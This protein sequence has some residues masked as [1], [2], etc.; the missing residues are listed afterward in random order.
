MAVTFKPWTPWGTPPADRYDPGL[1]A[2]LAASQR[3]YGDLI[4]DASTG[5]ARDTQDYGFG[6]GDIQRSQDRGLADL[7][8]QRTQGTEDYNRNVGLLQRSYQQLGTR[9]SEQARVAG[10]AGGGAAL[11]AARKRAENQAIDRQPLDT[12]YQRLLGGLDTAQTRLGEDSDIARGRLNVNYLR[13]IDDRGQQVLRGGR[14]SVFFGADTAKA[15]SFQA[16][17]TGWDPGPK[18]SNE[19]VGAKGAQRTIT[20]GNTVYVVDSAGNV[21]SKRAKRR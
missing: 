21:L 19:F 9:Q 12:G 8:T 15:K 4:T 20:R 16:A 7:G 14:E 10:I 6:L 17:G 2:S 13:G 3:G 18:P 5:N 11:Q 1:D